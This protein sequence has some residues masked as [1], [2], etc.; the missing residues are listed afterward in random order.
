[1]R[2]VTLYVC[3][4]STNV[5]WCMYNRRP[6]VLW[7]YYTYG[8]VVLS[9]GQSVSERVRAN[10]HTINFNEVYFHFLIPF[11]FNYMIIL[12]L[13]IYC[14][15]VVVSHVQSLLDLILWH[16]VNSIINDVRLLIYTLRLIC[17]DV[18]LLIVFL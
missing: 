13:I 11:F 3:L 15:N 10:P 5:Q 1:M 4:L 14:Y 2:N 6:N 8:T 7:F 9:T 16:V 12:S 18:R 17:S